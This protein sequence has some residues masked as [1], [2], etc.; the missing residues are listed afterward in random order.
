MF[1]FCHNAHSGLRDYLRTLLEKEIKG[2]MGG[3]P[4]FEADNGVFFL[5]PFALLNERN[6]RVSGFVRPLS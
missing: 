2:Y 6:L 1:P 4:D 3:E 5:L